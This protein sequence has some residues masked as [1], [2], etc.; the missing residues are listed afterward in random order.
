MASKLQ[1]RTYIFRRNTS[2]KLNTKVRNKKLRSVLVFTTHV[3]SKTSRR[4]LTIGN[5][6]VRLTFNLSKAKKCFTIV[7]KSILKLVE[8]PSLVAKCCKTWKIWPRKVCKFV[9]IYIYIYIHLYSYHFCDNFSSKMVTSSSRNTNI[10]KFANFARLYFPCFT[11]F[12][13]QTWQ[14]Y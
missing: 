4:I 8:M 11:T 1:N 10:Y 9:Y 7:K 2:C 6:H 5:L 13:D 12:R 14:F 3:G